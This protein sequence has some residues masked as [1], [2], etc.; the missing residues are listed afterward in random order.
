MPNCG[1]GTATVS[2][3]ESTVGDKFLRCRIVMLTAASVVGYGIA[4]RTDRT[5]TSP[6]MQVPSVRAVPR[7]KY[8]MARLT[9]IRTFALSNNVEHNISSGSYSTDL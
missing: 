6:I 5:V 1:D 2:T 9:S 7:H 4:V 8:G 3:R